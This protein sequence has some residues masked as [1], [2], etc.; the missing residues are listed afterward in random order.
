MRSRA[1]KRIDRSNRS[2]RKTPYDTQIWTTY[3]LSPYL[4]A[5]ELE[6]SVHDGKATL[7]GKV[8]EGAP[9][10]SSERSCAERALAIEL[11]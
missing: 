11:A 10:K 5:N 2:S 9:A 4:R 7:S 6:V 3:A 1:T 8:D